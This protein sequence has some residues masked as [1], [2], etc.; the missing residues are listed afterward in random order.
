MCANKLLTWT[1]RYNHASPWTPFKF[2]IIESSFNDL[3]ADNSIN[4]NFKFVM[5]KVLIGIQL[6]CKR[7]C[8]CHLSVFTNP[9]HDPWF[10]ILKSKKLQKLKRFH[11]LLGSKVTPGKTTYSLYPLYCEYSWFRNINMLDYRVCPG[12]LQHCLCKIQNILN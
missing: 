3:L 8:Y 12:P 2:S 6:T 11:D 9:R 7:I 4:Y 10:V 1:G 5:N